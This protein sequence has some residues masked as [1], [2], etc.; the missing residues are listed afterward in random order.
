MSF[1]D[2]PKFVI[3]TIDLITDSAKVACLNSK[4]IIL[5]VPADAYNEVLS[6]IAPWIQ[7]G[8]FIGCISGYGGFSWIAKHILK[9]K[10]IELDLNLWALSVFPFACRIL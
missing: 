9:E 8:A 5:A 3:G 10:I 4:I 7:R 6:K 1:Q 2:S